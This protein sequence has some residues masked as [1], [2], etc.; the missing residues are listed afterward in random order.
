MKSSIFLDS[1]AYSAWT[2]N[3][4]LAVEDY[5][6]YIKA[7]IDHIDIYANLDVIGSAEGTWENQRKM[8]AAG[9]KPLP[10][11]HVNEEPKYLA[12]CMEYDY[13]AVG[14]MAKT[15]SAVLQ[16]QID[17]VFSIICPQS[18]DYYPTHK[19]HG[20][21]CT[22]PNLVVG[23][24]WY[25]V[26]S[27]SWVKYGLY[28]IVLIPKIFNGRTLYDKPPMTITLSSRS[29][30]VGESHH[31]NNIPKMEQEAISNYFAEKGLPLGETEVYDVEPGY[32]LGDGESWLNKEKTKIEFV[33]VPGLTN[34]HKIRDHANLL[35]FLD[36]EK[37]QQ[38]WPWPWKK[39]TGRLF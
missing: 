11:Y 3:K 30:S 9:L 4:P 21:G 28:G 24:P 18:N 25:S 38:A 12:M 14:G 34:D 35:Y 36:L 29:K 39:R 22:K 37:Y 26:D 17:E 1:G 33:S 8:E 32:K 13:F 20:F 10:V 6:E 16:Y 31:F 2:S 7:N 5:I 27:S 23:Y 15:S 19:I